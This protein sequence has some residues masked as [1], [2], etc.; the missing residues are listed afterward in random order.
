MSE[1]QNTV[2]GLCTVPSEQV[3]KTIATILV[4][5]RAA[6]CGNLIPNLTSIYWWDNKINQ[7]P[8]FL[9]LIKT[10]HQNIPMVVELVKQNHPYQVP[11]IIFLPIIAGN[12]VYLDWIQNES[13]PSNSK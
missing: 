13:N 11:E 6:A 8:E 4:E 7:D 2:M 1:Q 10:T 3:G 9:L 12:A 5:N